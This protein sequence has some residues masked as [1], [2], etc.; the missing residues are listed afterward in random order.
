MP[1]PT[2]SF[3]TAILDRPQRWDAAFDP[4]MLDAN[5]DRLLSIAPF[6]HM[7]PESFPAR[8]PLRDI[9]KHDT[10]VHTYRRGEIVMREGDYGTS[11]FLVLSGVVRVVLGPGLPASVLGRRLSF[12]K[13]IFKAVA[14]LWA[15]QKAPESFSLRDLKKDLSARARAGR[16][17]QDFS[18]GRSPHP[19]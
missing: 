3:S 5:V 6:S 15:Y 11:A 19:R 13:N 17:S 8:L 18:A 10:R 16:R 4:E 14:Q 7:K 1:N 12:R 9:L 2:T